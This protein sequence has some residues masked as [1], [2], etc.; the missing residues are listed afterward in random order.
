MQCDACPDLPTPP[1]E[2]EN[3]S[4]ATLKSEPGVVQ[5]ASPPKRPVCDHCRRRRIR[6]DGQSPCEQCVSASLSCKREHIPK[7]RGPKRGH[8]RVINDIRA[9]EKRSFRQLGSKK[10]TDPNLGSLPAT[11]TSANDTAPGSPIGTPMPWSS[12]RRSL[13]HVNFAESRPDL[14]SDTMRPT[15]GD[16]LHLIPDCV[17]LYNEHIYPIMPLLYMPHIREMIARPLEPSGKSLIYALCAVTAFHMSGKSLSSPD[18]SFS[19]EAVG[20]FFLDECMLVRKDPQYDFLED[21]SL[22]TV[23]SSFWMSTSFF[24]IGQDRKSWFYLVQAMNLALELSLHDE[25][26]YVGLRPEDELCRRRVFWILFVTERSFAIFRKKPLTLRRTP[27]LPTTGHHYETPDIHSGFM[28]VVNSYVPLD[29][30]FVNAWNDSAS[31]GSKENYRYLSTYLNLQHTLAQPLVWRQQ[32]RNW[33]MGSSAHV[34]AGDPGIEPEPTD[35]QKADLLM[36]QQWLRLVVWLSSFR[37]GLLFLD[38]HESMG[39]HFP[40]TIASDTVRILQS[41]PD[42]AIEVHGMGIFEKIFKIGMWYVKILAYSSATAGTSQRFSANINV[43]TGMDFI[44]GNLGL[45]D[46]GGRRGIRIDPLEFFV[47]TLSSSPN[48]RTKYAER[49]LRMAEETPEATRFNLSPALPWNMDTAS[50]TFSNGTNWNA[51]GQIMG[52]VEE[53][54]QNQRPVKASMDHTVLV[55]RPEVTNNMLLD[56]PATGSASYTTSFAA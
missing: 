38:T 26:S 36:T 24:E 28:K 30:A 14:S 40:L 35:I 11:P 50:F 22:S 29:E 34:E 20:R 17:E 4:E 23:I 10:K 5:Q 18:S 49:L 47:K 46:R 45:L 8:G 39:S 37:R 25:T 44:R 9:Q 43:E 21:L 33:P 13:N 41:L 2:R 1:L 31:G 6:C 48:S 52:E 7:K 32:R 12:L 51:V 42:H 3:S 54:D 55:S 16:Y 19:W 15:S 53:A 56:L 27:G